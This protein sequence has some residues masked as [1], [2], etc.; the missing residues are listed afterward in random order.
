MQYVSPATLHVHA[1]RTLSK[2]FFLFVCLFFVVVCLFVCLF[3]CLLVYK[4]LCHID[5]GYT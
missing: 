5:K 3:V 2:S 4:T 1:F